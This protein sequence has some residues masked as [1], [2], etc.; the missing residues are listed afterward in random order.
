[1]LFLSLMM[2]C[3]AAVGFAA[4]ADPI[5]VS[6]LSEP[7]SVIAPQEVDITIKVYNSSQTDM[8]EKI[9]LYN[10]TGAPVE[11]YEGLKG[12]QS[13]TYQGVWNVTAEEIAKGKFSYYIQYTIQEAGGPKETIR[14]VPVTIQTEAA[15]PQLTATYTVSP[16]S[17]RTGQTVTVAYTLSN[18]GNIELRDIVLRTRRSP[19]RT[20]PPF[21]SPWARR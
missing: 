9:T 21:R 8:Q 10:P 5:R 3:Y 1:M 19:R 4:E 2:M 13:V 17:A 16:A 11:S 20:S 14:S 6:S 18:T 15:A 12:E 7:Q